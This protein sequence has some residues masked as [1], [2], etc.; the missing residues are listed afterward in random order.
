[1]LKGMPPGHPLLTSAER[2]ARALVAAIERERAR[3]YVPA[4]P[5]VALVPV[6]KYSP[7]WLL[8]KLT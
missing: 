1:M 3:S 5:W 4:W 7:M 6:A 2:G 8:R